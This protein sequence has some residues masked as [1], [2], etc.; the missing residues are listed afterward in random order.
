MWLSGTKMVECN[1]RL[2]DQVAVISFQPLKMACTKNRSCKKLILAYGFQEG[3]PQQF[4]HHH[5]ILAGYA[6]SFP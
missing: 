5:S 2:S 4:R 6:F 1:W 3:N